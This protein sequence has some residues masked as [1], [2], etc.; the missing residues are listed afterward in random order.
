MG[1]GGV[2]IQEKNKSVGLTSFNSEGC[3]IILEVV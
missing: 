2:L 1:F 3:N